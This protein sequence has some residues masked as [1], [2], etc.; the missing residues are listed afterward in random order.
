MTDNERPKR[1]IELKLLHVQALILGGQ[2]K[3]M[4]DLKDSSSTK[5][6]KYA[7]INQGRY[8]SKLYTPGEF[9]ATEISR[10]S[11]IL[12]INPTI[13]MDIIANEIFEEEVARV[14]ENMSKVN[15]KK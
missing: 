13:I 7:G 2:I 10:I 3:R 14:A 4:R 5:I 9:T 8:A 15:S 11:Y 12:D 1:A 6:A